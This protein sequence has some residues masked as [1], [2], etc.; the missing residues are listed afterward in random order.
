[1][2]KLILLFTL[3]LSMA[4]S[5]YQYSSWDDYCD[6]KHNRMTCKPSNFDQN[7]L[8]WFMC[9]LNHN[10][11]CVSNIRQLPAVRSSLPENVSFTNGTHWY[12][13][14]Q[15]FYDDSVI[16]FAIDDIKGFR[17]FKSVAYITVYYYD[18]DTYRNQEYYPGENDVNLHAIGWG[19]IIKIII[20][21][22]ARA[23]CVV[24]FQMED[25][26]GDSWEI[27]GEQTWQL[28]SERAL[29][30][31]SYSVGKGVKMQF[32]DGDLPDV[33]PSLILGA[34]HSVNPNATPNR[35]LNSNHNSNLR[36]LD[37]TPFD[38]WRNNDG[39]C[40]TIRFSTKNYK[41]TH[42]LSTSVSPRFISICS[43]NEHSRCFDYGNPSY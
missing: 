31:N 29:S 12:H 21:P 40:E 6:M 17:N 15:S 28:D 5:V 43:N 39:N 24:F 16:P 30:F 35:R 26:I 33:K 8:K 14:S 2:L 9:V 11:D 1:M 19:W 22:K 20:H 36:I 10:K 38:C 13:A 25:F 32:F 23:G 34:L 41:Y 4:S 7:N 18:G 37:P 42:A 27:C 3:C